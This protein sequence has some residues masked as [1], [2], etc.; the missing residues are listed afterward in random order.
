MSRILV[1]KAWQVAGFVKPRINVSQWRGLFPVKG[2]GIRDVLPKNTR[3]VMINRLRMNTEATVM[4][5]GGEAFNLPSPTFEF[6]EIRIPTYSTRNQYT[7]NRHLID[8]WNERNLSYV[9]A[10]QQAAQLGH[11]YLREAGALVGFGGAGEGLLG[12]QGKTIVPL[13]LATDVAGLTDLQSQN[14]AEV[15]KAIIA[16]ITNLTAK[17]FINNA[18]QRV[19]I[20]TALRTINQLKQKWIPMLDN[21]AGMGPSIFDVI[22]DSIKRLNLT[23]EIIQADRF[24]SGYKTDANGAITADPKF[25]LMW[26]TIPEF[27]SDEIVP[28]VEPYTTGEPVQAQ[29]INENFLMFMDTLIPTEYP[30]LVQNGGVT[31]QLEVSAITAGIVIRPDTVTMIGVKV[32]A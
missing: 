17:N 24:C 28:D 13:L 9:E 32:V 31:T 22:T 18:G 8:Q 21:G 10:A 4:S 12:A 15:A 25:D 14:P 16:D 3:Q 19:V 26:I 2:D 5:V 30:T 6:G 27:D 7:F 1:D 29:N 20:T 11:K 23:V